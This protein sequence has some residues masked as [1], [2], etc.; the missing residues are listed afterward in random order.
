MIFIFSDKYLFLERKKLVQCNLSFLKGKQN[1]FRAPVNR[2]MT[3]PIQIK[4]F[5]THFFGSEQCKK[6]FFSLGKIVHSKSFIV[7]IFFSV[8]IVVFLFNFYY[9]FSV[10]QNESQGK[11]K[12]QTYKYIYLENIFLFIPFS[13]VLSNYGKNRSQQ[14]NGSFD[15]RER[16]RWNVSEVMEIVQC[17]MC[18]GDFD[19]FSQRKLSFFDCFSD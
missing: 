1:Y 18:M 8:F 17:T 19:C 9:F 14:G 7:G 5:H 13:C 10:S 11:Q 4:I 2:T 16:F 15:T 3:L 6:Y 12:Q